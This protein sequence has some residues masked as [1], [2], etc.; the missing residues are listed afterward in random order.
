M[1]ETPK[2]LTRREGVSF[3]SPTYCASSVQPLRPHLTF[4]GDLQAWSLVWFKCIFFFKIPLSWSLERLSARVPVLLLA[5][6]GTHPSCLA[7]CPEWGQGLPVCERSSWVA[8][9]G[10]IPRPRCH[11]LCGLKASLPRLLAPSQ[12][13]TLRVWGLFLYSFRDRSSQSR[14]DV[15]LRTRDLE[16]ERFPPSGSRSSLPQARRLPR[17]CPTF[18]SLWPI[19][20]LFC[21]GLR[22]V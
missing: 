17:K 18:V 3:S 19:M 21:L 11:E 14:G 4:G 6:W 12:L 10:E 16:E 7:G 22:G 1:A 9:P 8:S 15:V 20:F 2:A 13:W 5:A